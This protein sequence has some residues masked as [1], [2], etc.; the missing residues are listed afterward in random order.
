MLAD[1][2]SGAKNTAADQRFVGEGDRDLEMFRI[3][4]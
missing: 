2:S 3:S 4:S 1:A